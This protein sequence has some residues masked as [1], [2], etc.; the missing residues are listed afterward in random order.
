MQDIIYREIILEHYKNPQNYGILTPAD[1]DVTE[2]NS[3]C[4]DE[5]HVTVRIN[6]N[7]VSDIAF[8]S[9]GCAI[10]KASAS[11]FTEELKGKSLNEIA[12]I[13]Q[14]DVLSLLEVQLTP[15]RIKCALLIYKTVN[16]G[17]TKS[18]L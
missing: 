18:G 1:I 11:L 8:E 2:L 3:L 4:G 6:N 10:S 16:K 9:Q 17:I 13:S 12:D 15:A 14:K 5:I 7:Y